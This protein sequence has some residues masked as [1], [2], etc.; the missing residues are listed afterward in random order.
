MPIRSTNT[1]LISI[2]SRTPTRQS[3]SSQPRASGSVAM[4]KMV[5]YGT[6]LIAEVAEFYFRTDSDYEVS[7][8]TNAAE[9]IADKSFHGK[10]L[11]PFEDIEGSYS[12]SEF[13]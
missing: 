4:K 6:G 1:R 8:F 9:F 11:V 5:I 7:A 13:D 3:V 2:A 12:A 10:P